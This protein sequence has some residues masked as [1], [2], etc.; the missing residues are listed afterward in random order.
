MARI[1]GNK[2]NT[3]DGAQRYKLMKL[4]EAGYTAAALHDTEFAVKMAEELGFPVT[5]ANVQGAREALGIESTLDAERRQ[6]HEPQTRL[7]RIEARLAA[8]EA[9][10]KAFD[11]QA[12]L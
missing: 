7:D 12:K 9:W 3:L 5:R 8:I 11:P 4:V 6:R 1:P 10:I 2:V